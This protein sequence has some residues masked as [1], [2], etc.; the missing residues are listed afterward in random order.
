MLELYLIVKV[1][2]A[3]CIVVL[4]EVLQITGIANLLLFTYNVSGIVQ[5]FVC[6]LGAMGLIL[7]A[8]L[9]LLRAFEIQG[10]TIEVGR[11]C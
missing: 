3:C 9:I 7:H 10:N 2:F 4:H 5:E 11:H 8:E 6:W 1:C